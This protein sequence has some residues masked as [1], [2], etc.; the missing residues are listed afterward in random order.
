MGGVLML[1]LN[2]KEKFMV[3]FTILCTILLTC[4]LACTV[5]LAAFTTNKQA[6]TTI[7]FHEGITIEITEGVSG[8]NKQWEYAVNGGSTYSTSNVVALTQLQ[9]RN[10]KIKVTKGASTA[11]PCYI[12]VFYFITINSTTATCLPTSS[13]LNGLTKADL[14]TNETTFV[15]SNKFSTDSKYI[16]Y[17]GTGS[18]T[19]INTVTPII[20]INPIT[21]FNIKQQDAAINGKQVRAYFRVYAS[22]DPFT[23]E[24]QS[25]WNTSYFTFSF[26]S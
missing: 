8:D 6:T 17:A 11:S 3:G 13:D 1:K 26:G 20:I 2:A 16:A 9:M 24:N 18:I 22:T 4:A 19:A 25:S 10:V 23:T 7:K 5:V 15:N 14:S 12:R 21:V